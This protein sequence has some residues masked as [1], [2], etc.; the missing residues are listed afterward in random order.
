[1]TQKTPAPQTGKTSMQILSTPVGFIAC[2]SVSICCVS[3]YDDLQFCFF[4]FDFFYFDAL[5]S[6]MLKKVTTLWG[7]ASHRLTWWRG[8]PVKGHYTTISETVQNLSDIPLCAEYTSNSLQYLNFDPTIPWHHSIKREKKMSLHLPYSPVFSI[9][10]QL[11]QILQLH[12][13]S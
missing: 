1:M 12:L 5:Y 9:P 6:C 13:Q 3:H 10:Q 11:S 8:I 2:L 7:K 4:Y